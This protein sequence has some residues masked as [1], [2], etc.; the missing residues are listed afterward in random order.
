ML[1]VTTELY[2]WEIDVAGGRIRLVE[3]LPVPEGGPPR[4]HAQ[5][6][7]F[8]NADGIPDCYATAEK[9]ADG[10]AWLS[11]IRPPVVGKMITLVYASSGKAMLGSPVVTIEE[12]P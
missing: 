9:D 7:P 8:I 2:R 10:W 12:T 3:K 4:H 6:A 11:S 5:H 1:N